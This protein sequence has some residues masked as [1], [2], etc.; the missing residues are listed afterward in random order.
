[1]SVETRVPGENILRKCTELGSN[2]GPT[3]CEATA[4]TTALLCYGSI[5]TFIIAKICITISI[6]I[7]HNDNTYSDKLVR[8]WCCVEVFC[9]F[10][11]SNRPFLV[12]F[13]KCGW[14]TFQLTWST[15]AA[16]AKPTQNILRTAKLKKW[17]HQNSKRSTNWMKRQLRVR[18]PWRPPVRI[19]GIW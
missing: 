1:M 7:L 16:H 11:F 9:V 2:P 6:I 17:E 4:L 15:V 14:P 10:G 5:G 18:K 12:I 3:C 13:S 8:V 19:L